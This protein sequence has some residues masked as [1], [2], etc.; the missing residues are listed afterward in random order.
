M[1]LDDTARCDGLKSPINPGK[2]LGICQD[3]MRRPVGPLPGSVWWMEPA[4]KHDGTE[5]QCS[6]RRSLGT[7]KLIN[8]EES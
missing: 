5:W 3:C 6:E 1:T 2:P 8:G 4:A 7:E